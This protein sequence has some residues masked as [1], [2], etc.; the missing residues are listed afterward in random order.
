MSG[1]K[2]VI[3]CL[4]E[5]SY[6]WAGAF[7]TFFANKGY[8]L[9]TCN[10]GK[11]SSGYMG[12][13]LA[14]PTVQ[15]EAVHVDISRLS[16]TRNEWP[17]EPE[18]NP[19]ARVWTGVQ[20]IMQPPLRKLGLIQETIDHWSMSE[21]RFNAL[22]TATLKER[23]S[24]RVFAIGNYHM[25]CAF[26]A[27]MVMSSKY[28][29]HCFCATSNTRRTFCLYLIRATQS[30]PRWQPSMFKRLPQHWEMCHTS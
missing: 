25:P 27:P 4:Q 22:I 29:F 15:F 7:S 1:Y 26:Y 10:Y 28:Q 12:V 21:R 6:D 17:I 8:H 16:D 23:E 9:V 3:V 11:K 20:S 19:I 30:M 13:C 18:L 14:W 2:N 24:G 5:V